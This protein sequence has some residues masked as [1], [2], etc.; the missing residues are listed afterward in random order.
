M[1]RMDGT[2]HASRK[3]KHSLVQ[4][5]THRGAL[6][7]RSAPWLAS[8]SGVFLG[9]IKKHVKDKKLCTKYEKIEKFQNFFIMKNV[10]KFPDIFINCRSYLLD[11]R[12]HIFLEEASCR[13]LGNYLIG[14]RLIFK[15][16]SRGSNS[17][18]VSPVCATFQ[19]R[20]EFQ[21]I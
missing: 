18:P 20:V 1:R 11:I 19:I 17:Q 16:E 9:Y 21:E 7:C 12:I 15:K 6:G 3:L 14:L 2:C 8:A 10:G 4:G 5:G 13:K